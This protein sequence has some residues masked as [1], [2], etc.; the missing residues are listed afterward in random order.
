MSGFIGQG[1][2]KSGI[3]G[4]PAIENSVSDYEEGTWTP[5]MGDGTNNATVT[6]VGQYIKI[7]KL[8]Y[9]RFEIQASNM[10]S[11]TS[12]GIRLQNFPFTS[13]SS[14]PYDVGS[15]WLAVG[16]QQESQRDVRIQM[17]PNI[18]YCEM[19]DSNFTTGTHA[20]IS[21]NDVDTGTLF[22]ITLWYH[23]A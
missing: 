19:V 8:C 23:T 5:G 20:A 22:R 9:L 10:G 14:L 21:G 12:G 16:M 15:S 2:S 6:S 18:N 7:G 3:I 4:L 13:T 11:I 17:N 1:G